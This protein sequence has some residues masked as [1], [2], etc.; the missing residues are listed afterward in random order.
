MQPSTQWDAL[1]AAY[2]ARL[3]QTDTS[4]RWLLTQTLAMAPSRRTLL[5]SLA[6]EDGVRLVDVGCGFGAHALEWATL[7][8]VTATGVDL[9]PEVLSI[10][11]DVAT[12]VSSRGGLAPGSTASF[13]RGNIYDLPMTSGATDVAVVQFVFQHLTDPAAAA[14]ELARVMRP[15]GLACVIDADDGLS[16]SEPPAS[17]A[18]T[19]LAAA[20]HGAQA[21]GG[22]DRHIGRKLAGILDESGFEPLTVLVIP[23]AAYVR[24]APGDPGRQLVAE[25]FRV[26]RESIIDSGQMTEDE[27]DSTL[28]AYVGERT[29][30][31]CEIE[32]Y[33]AV[34]AQRR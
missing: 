20:L 22:G 10:A 8:S 21:A 2:R 16:I 23:Q 24:P 29:G 5:S 18:Y 34:I 6:R 25:R 13:A 33:L 1:D 11:S 15:G 9:D 30:A 17:D 4:R 32:G 12:E 3:Q 27:F 7:R 19:R 14:A 26:G 28:A 31:V